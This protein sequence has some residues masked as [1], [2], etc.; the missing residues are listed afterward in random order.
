MEKTQYILD[1]TGAEAREYFLKES[2]YCD[3]KLPSYFTFDPLL[4]NIAETV[5]SHTQSDLYNRNL[6][7]DI[8]DVNYRLFTN[9]DGKYAWRQLDLIHPLLYILLVNQITRDRSWEKI[10]Q[11]FAEFRQPDFPIQCVSIPVVPKEKEKPDAL[12][13]KTWWTELEQRSVEYALDY[14]YIMHTDVTDCYP[15]IYTWAISLALDGDKS[16]PRSVGSV[17]DKFLQDMQHGQKRGLP[18][19]SSLMN[20]IA[21]IVLGYSDFLLMRKLQNEN[22]EEYKI[23]RYRDDYRIFTNNPPDGDQILKSLGEVMRSLGM[24]LHPQK[25]EASSDVIWS[26]IKPDKRT[27][28]MRKQQEKYLQKH[29]MIIHDHSTIHPNAGSLLRAL[30][31]FRDRLDKKNDSQR[32][33]VQALPLISIATDIAYRNPRTYPQVFSIISKCLQYLSKEDRKGVLERVRNKLSKVT[34]AG[35]RDIWLQRLCLPYDSV[36]FEEPLCK[37]VSETA[38]EIW[39]NSWIRAEEVKKAVNA[40]SIVNRDLIQNL[41]QVIDRKEIELFPLTYGS[42]N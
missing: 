29:L 13:V 26:S 38:S 19:G 10:L 11:R 6:I 3:F 7:R 31:E 14:E 2:S 22:L 39:N 33:Y 35:H 27:W 20:L 42:D 17:I 37:L 15:S 18:Q 16:S 8:D 21:E 30:T 12:Q 5:P 34:N 40:E 36:V 4:K 23:L 32:K 9:K 25:T 41:P 24:K 28:I 1:L